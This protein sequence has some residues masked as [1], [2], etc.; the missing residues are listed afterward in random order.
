ME[1]HAKRHGEISIIKSSQRVVWTWPWATCFSFNVALA[2]SRRL[3]GTP[4]EVSSNLYL[5]VNLIQIFWQRFQILL[6]EKK[7]QILHTPHPSGQKFIGI[8]SFLISTTLIWLLPV[9]ILLKPFQVWS[10]ALS[11]CSV[12]YLGDTLTWGCA[13]GKA[14]LSRPCSDSLQGIIYNTLQELQEISKE[15]TKLQIRSKQRTSPTQIV[16]Q[17]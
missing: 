13:A 11:M 14:A 12:P 4:A 1:H 6:D 3:D 2:W 17:L 8:L 9:L 5:S 15:I 16:I 10:Y 7:I